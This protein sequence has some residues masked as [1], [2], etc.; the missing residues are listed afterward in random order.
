MAKHYIVV[1][2]GGTQ[3]RAALA[4]SP[5]RLYQT[6]RMET[7]ADQGPD[8]SA[9]A[10]FLPGGYPELYDWSCR[11]LEQFWQSVWRFGSVIAET[12]GSVEIGRAS[13]RERV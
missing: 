8:V 5:N 6:I 1:D 11:E 2:L 7:L 4:T 12:Q 10:V 3:I 13:C 9:D